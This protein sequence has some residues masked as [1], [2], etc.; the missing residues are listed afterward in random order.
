[1]A[2]EKENIDDGQLVHVSM[3][4]EFLA[5]FGADGGDREVD[6]VHCLDFGGLNHTFRSD[7]LVKSF[8]MALNGN[9]VRW[10]R[11]I[12]RIPVC[13]AETCNPS[14]NEYDGERGSNH[15]QNSKGTNRS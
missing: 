12:S 14:R 6:G 2:L 5:D 8:I 9:I 7:L 1:M 4:L 13:L 11:R 3:A 10:L 15:F